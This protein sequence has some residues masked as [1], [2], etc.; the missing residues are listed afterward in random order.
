MFKAVLV[1]LGDEV[2]CVDEVGLVGDC[3]GETGFC[4]VRGCAAGEGG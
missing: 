3:L 1:D 4:V 2:F